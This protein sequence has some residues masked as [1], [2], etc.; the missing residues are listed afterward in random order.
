MSLSHNVQRRMVGLLTV[1]NGEELFRNSSRVMPAL[2]LRVIT[3]T[4]QIIVFA[5]NEALA[6]YNYFAVVLI[7]NCHQQNNVKFSLT[8]GQAYVV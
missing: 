4:C 6:N 7:W 1:Q 5:I 3:K 8:L 2:T